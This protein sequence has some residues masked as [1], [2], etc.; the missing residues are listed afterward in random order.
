MLLPQWIIESQSL[1]IQGT[2][3][4]TRAP[5]HFYILSPPKEKYTLM[6]FEHISILEFTF[7]IK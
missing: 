6:L 1:A 4:T 2:I 7:A 3:I 5:R